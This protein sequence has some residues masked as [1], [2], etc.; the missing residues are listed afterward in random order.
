MVRRM[1]SG[2]LLLVSAVPAFANESYPAPRFTDPRRVAKLESAFSAIDKI[3]REYANSRH[4]P[5]LSWGVVIDGRVAHIG[6]SGVRDRKSNAPVTAA[7]VFRI[8]SMT[9][10]FTALA[11]LKLRDESKLTLEDPVSKWIP[12]FARMELPTRDSGPIRI[13]HLMTHGTG[14]PEDN[15][16][17]DQ[18]L[19]KSDAD[20]TAWLKQGI[21]FSSVPDTQFEY[22]N[23]GFALLGRIVTG[24]AGMPYEAYLQTEIL[25]PLKMT[26]STLE[27]AKVAPASAAVGYRRTPTGS[28][29]EEPSLPHGA[30]GAMGGL[31]TSANDL[32]RY[33]AF[34]LS[35]WPPRDDAETGPVLRNSVREM[36]HIWRVSA[37]AVS[38]PG[39]TLKAE[40]RGYG[41]GLRV[42]ADCR[43]DHISNHSGGLPGF[44]SH[45]A[46]LPEY[47][48][49]MFAMA[50]L[51]YV[52]PAQPVSD[53]W[54]ALLN[55][56]GLRK[57]ELPASPLLTRMRDAIAKLWTSWNDKDANEIAA[58]NLFLDEPTE[59]RREQ[60]EKLKAE[61]GSCSSA[62]PVVPE[63]WLRGQ[64]NMSCSNGN[65]GVFFSLAPTQPP[66]IQHL[67]F[68]RIPTTSARL[69]AP[70]S[71]IPAVTCSE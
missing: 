56:G 15:P 51:T 26:A 70:T 48:V 53:A 50:N 28:Y 12:E 44:G 39:G 58:M 31:L 40:L 7:T 38:R 37:L 13:R 19:G 68:Q 66:R 57:R 54:N 8:A 55:T 62:G 14:F 64:F 65:I 17:G 47:G 2:L 35:A 18:Q 49:G 25:T 11:I 33:V 61:V 22:S 42:G 4:I 24:A 43:F 36:N 10:S 32:G 1:R 60:I 30:F 16:W 69:T 41:F 67:S 21:P 34:Q 5:G 45:M 59:Q 6:S 23:Y 3:F 63:N 71:S 20:L 27:A 46:W 29:L 9:K 52:G